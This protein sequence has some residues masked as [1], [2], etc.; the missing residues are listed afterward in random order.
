MAAEINCSRTS[1]HVHEI[2]NDFALNVAADVVEQKSDSAVVDF[3]EGLLLVCFE[4]V[5]SDV[6]FLVIG[7]SLVK[8]G[9][10]FVVLRSLVIR[11]V[12]FHV[13]KWEGDG[14]RLS[15]FDRDMSGSIAH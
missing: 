8:G 12:V 4:F 10:C 1:V 14:R 2:V 5:Q 13:W 3:D 6:M 7:Y 9:H 11:T 15:Y